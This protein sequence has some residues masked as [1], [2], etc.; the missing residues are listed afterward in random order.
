MFPISESQKRLCFFEISVRL[1]TP[2]ANTGSSIHT[3]STKW[4]T[5]QTTTAK[6]TTIN[7]NRNRNSQL[8]M[9]QRR[10][11]S[12]KLQQQHRTTIR[13]IPPLVTIKTTTTNNSNNNNNN[14]W[15]SWKTCTMKTIPRH[16]NHNNMGSNTNTNQ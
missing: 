6:K 1:K 8:C 16:S 9:P 3:Y 4:T 15:N 13:P 10:A 11:Q 12:R 14:T 5:T 2:E 7:S